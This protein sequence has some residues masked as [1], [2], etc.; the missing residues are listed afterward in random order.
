MRSTTKSKYFYSYLQTEP[1]VKWGNLA[2]VHG[3]YKFMFCFQNFHFHTKI[4]NFQYFLKQSPRH[5]MRCER[6]PILD[7]C[8]S[9]FEVA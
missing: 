9:K 2:L 8:K 3:F 6:N 5:T 4:A 1:I 7:V